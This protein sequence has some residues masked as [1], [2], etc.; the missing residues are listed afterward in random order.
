MAKK[1]K[2]SAEYKRVRRN[3]LQRIRR[4]TNRGYEIDIDI[5]AIPKKITQASIR[6][7]E[8]MDSEY[9]HSHSKKLTPIVSE[10]TGFTTF[11]KLSGTEA[12][13]IE[14]SQA[15]KKAA[16]T[17]KFKAEHGGMTPS[18]WYG[19]M[20]DYYNYAPDDAVY[21]MDTDELFERYRD[22][23]HDYFSANSL[24]D[25]Q[26]TVIDKLLSSLATLAVA[27]ELQFGTGDSFI[28]DLGLTEIWNYYHANGLSINI[29]RVSALV[30]LSEEDTRILIEIAEAS[31]AWQLD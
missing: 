30:H 13:K 8:R 31:E 14:R 23:L 19:D 3:L 4:M 17:R 1:S 27:E 24:S 15:A 11:K 9:L 6:R 21:I 25:A 2:Y 18:K 22:Q 26:Q 16:K 20:D 29:G 10:E 12:R 7:L 5:P 28:D